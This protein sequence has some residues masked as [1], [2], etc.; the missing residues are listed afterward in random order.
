MDLTDDA[1]P[2][3]PLPYLNSIHASAVTCIAHVEDVAKEIYAK[4]VAAGKEDKKVKFT[5]R[6]WPLCGGDVPEEVRLEI[7][8]GGKG[9]K[10]S[11]ISD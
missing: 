11:Q 6:S 7:V 3:Y 1:W 2:V 5:E 10:N 9:G 8:Y 4:I